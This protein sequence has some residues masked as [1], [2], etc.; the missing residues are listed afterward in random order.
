MTKDELNL[1]LAAGG[2]EESMVAGVEMGE[3]RKETWSDLL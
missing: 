2:T 1:L 3:K